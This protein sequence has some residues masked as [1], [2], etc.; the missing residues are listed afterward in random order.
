METT[1]SSRCALIRIKMIIEALDTSS[2][3]V[4]VCPKRTWEVY[5]VVVVAIESTL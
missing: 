3:C 5:A 1:D 4:T 2:Q